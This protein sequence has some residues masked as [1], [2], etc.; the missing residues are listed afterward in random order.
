MSFSFDVNFDGVEAGRPMLTEGFYEVNIDKAFPSD[1][2]KD[3]ILFGL[4]FQNNYKGQT[5]LYGLNLPGTTKNGGD[6]R[7]LWLSLMVSCG[8]DEGDLKSGQQ[9]ISADQIVGQTAYIYFKPRDANNTYDKFSFL[10]KDEW[11]T[12]KEAFGSKG[13]TGS[14]T[15]TTVPKPNLDLGGSTKETTSGTTTTTATNTLTSEDLLGS[16]SPS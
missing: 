7:G 11:D 9:K 4:Q 13:T 12:R 6:V 10:T 8:Y 15:T 3:R 2:N 1:G 16:I 14:K 5:K